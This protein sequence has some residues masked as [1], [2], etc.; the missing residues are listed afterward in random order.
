MV[1]KLALDGM[2]ADLAVVDTLLEGRS[3]TNDPIGYMQLSRRREKLAREIES[4]NGASDLKASVALFFAGQP[5]VGSRGI[6]VDFA[7]RAIELFQQLVAKQFATEEIGEIGRRGP[8]PLRSNSDLLLTDIARGSVGFMLEE[9]DHN[10]VIV[11]T[12]L[13]IVVD[14]V[15]ETIFA[16]TEPSSDGFEEL[17]ETIDHRNLA[18]LSEFF[19]L[20]DDERATIRIVEG[21]RDVQLDSSSIR[22]GRDRTGNTQIDERESDEF[23]GRLFLLPAHR[24]FELL[25]LQGK[26]TI[27]G[28]VSSELAR[29]QLDRVLADGGVV[30]QNWRVRIRIRSLFRPNREPKTTYTLLG[31]IEGVA[32]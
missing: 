18:T 12:E 9:A 31:L 6:K 21:D 17:L 23:I 2:Q 14:H 13:K 16:A 32:D 1:R 7:G 10:D 3:S 25:Q 4:A 15:T 24:R 29:G 8:V 22:R 27:Y 19:C 30:G 5:V 28:S 26:G 20:L 11:E